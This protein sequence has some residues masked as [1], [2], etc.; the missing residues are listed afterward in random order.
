MKR[1][2]R[3]PAG[4]ETSFSLRSKVDQ[5]LDDLLDKDVVEE[6]NWMKK[7]GEFRTLWPTGVKLV[8][9]IGV[10]YLFNTREV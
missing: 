10:R 7:R 1:H 8:Q 6:Y 3:S 2:A 5:N 4:A 9:K